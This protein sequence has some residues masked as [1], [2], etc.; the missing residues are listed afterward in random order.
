M[1]ELLDLYQRTVS[2]KYSIKYPQIW[3]MLCYSWK[4]SIEVHVE[5][6]QTPMMVL[7]EEIVNGWKVFTAFRRRLS[8]RCLTSD[9][10]L[11]SK[12]TYRFSY[13]ITSAAN[14]CPFNM[15]YFNPLS[16]NPA[17]WSNTLN[18][19]TKRLSFWSLNWR[20]NTFL[21]M[22]MDISKVGPIDF[23]GSRFSAK[24]AL[25]QQH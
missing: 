23:T 8:L 10:Y 15:P 7:F 25:L 12:D 4:R 5:A 18:S 9:Q 14:G 2:A 1:K 21:L 24:T 3:N 6:S 13:L 20:Q 17:K 11:L 16:T 19:S 22:K